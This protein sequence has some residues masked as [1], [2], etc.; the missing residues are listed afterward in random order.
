MELVRLPPKPHLAWTDD[1]YMS[2]T[3]G[4]TAAQAGR[5]RRCPT[6]LAGARWLGERH[7]RNI[8]HIT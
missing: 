1:E 5:S 2:N 7:D 4:I 3:F 6:I 8:V